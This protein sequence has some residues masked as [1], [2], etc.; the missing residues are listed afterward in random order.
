MTRGTDRYD[1]THGRKLGVG[2]LASRRKFGSQ[3]LWYLLC[4][5]MTICDPP[6]A[7]TKKL[8]AGFGSVARRWLTNDQRW[9]TFHKQLQ[10]LS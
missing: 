6:P 5:G 7:G 3:V 1:T 2:S 4:M 8:L 9:A 10:C